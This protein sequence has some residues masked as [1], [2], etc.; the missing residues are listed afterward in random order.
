MRR[1]FLRHPA[2]PLA[3]VIAALLSAAGTTAASDSS[4]FD[5]ACANYYRQGNDADVAADTAALF[6]TCL[7]GE[8]QKQGLGHDAL[9]FFARTYSDDLTTFIDQYPQGEAWMQQSF[10]ADKQCKSADHGAN[11]PAPSNDF[12]REAGSWGGVVRSG[13]GREFSRLGALAEGERITLVE[14]TGVM[15]ND[16][17]WFKIRY[18]GNREGYQWGGIVCGLGQPIDGAFETC[19]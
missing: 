18:R 10:R 4:A 14:N 17:S 11:E 13:P 2:A 6:C 15:D 7:A 19:R 9:E 5:G 16:Y 12:P 8:F 3:V 1:Q